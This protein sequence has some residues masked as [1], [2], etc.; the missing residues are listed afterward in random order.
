MQTPTFPALQSRYK[1][2]TG[3]RFQRDTNPGF[4]DLHPVVEVVRSLFLSSL[5]W[6]LLAATVYTV[7]TMIAGTH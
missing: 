2:F 6:A 7:Y 1:S 4:F 3:R 5:L